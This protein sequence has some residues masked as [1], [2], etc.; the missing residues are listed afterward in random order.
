S[1]GPLAF[2]PD[3]VLFVGDPEQAA[4]FAIA[5]EDREPASKTGP[6]DVAKLDAKIASLLGTTADQILIQDLAVNPISKK[7][8]L[9]VLRGKG[10]DAAPMLVRVGHD[11]KVQEVSLK[12]VKFS[13][14]TLP[15]APA[16]GTGRRNPRRDSIT[17]LAF[18]DGRLFV[19]G[20]SNEEFASKLR[21][22]PFPFKE[23]SKGVSVEI[24]HGA[25]GRFET[26]SPVRT[27]T[28]YRIDGD[29]YL[30]AAYTCTPLVKFPVSALKAGEKVKGIT[31]AE[32]G[33]RN[34]P[35]DMFVYQKGGKDFILV[36]NSARGVM[37]ITTDKIG[38]QDSIEK[39]IS[40][41]A[42]LTYESIKD[43]EGVVQLDRLDDGH[44]LMLVQG[45]D[46]LTLKSA[47][48][49]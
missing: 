40:G 35:L 29:A 12:N 47:P 7:A 38:T 17:D 9:S 46:G 30:L 3:G 45:S 13:R 19:A 36:A 2:G 26:R 25:H 16:A 33:N 4:V 14:A 21:S 27:F 20:L 37:K 22:I 1:V 6:Y 43:L 28:H 18:V 41:T 49:P 34:R 15:N 44:A 31:L 32:L 10:P 48:L 24:F 5:T 8:Y 11:G 39:K 42:G 23:T